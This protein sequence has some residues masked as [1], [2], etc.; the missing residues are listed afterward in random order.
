MQNKVLKHFQ[1][2]KEQALSDRGSSSAARKMTAREMC[3]KLM[4]PGTFVEINMF[5]KHRC[6]DF[7]MENKG[8]LGDSVVT[9]YGNIL[10]RPVFVYAQ[11][12]SVLGGSL[13]LAHAKKIWHIMDLAAKAGAPIVGLCDSAGARIQ[14]GTDALAG[15]GGIFLRNTRYSGVIPQITAIMGIC[16][17]GAVYSPAITD[18]IYIV[19]DACMFITGP[20]VVKEV[21]G[22]DVSMA[23]LGG[24]DIHTR[25]SGNADFLVDSPEECIG[26]IRKLLTYIPQNNREKPLQVD[27]RNPINSGLDIADIVPDDPRQPLNV[28]QLINAL[29]DNGDFYEVKAD[30]AKNIVVGFAHFAGQSVGILANQPEFMAGVLDS[31][32]SDKAARFVRLCDA[33]NIPL[34][35]LVDVPGYLPGTQ[36]EYKGIIR[37]GAKLLYAYSEATV[38][39]ITVILRK[40]YGGAY[41]GMCS[42]HLGADLVLSWPTAEIAVM[43]PEGAV[44]VIFKKTISSSSNPDET[45]RKLIQDYQDKFANPYDACFKQ[46]VDDVIEPGETRTRII[47]ALNML[48]DKL[49]DLHWRKHGN[50]PL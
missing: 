14:E 6:T 13:G 34:V 1:S 15:Y 16:A 26:Q 37:H 35:T 43:G 38:P 49:E 9:G 29:V 17:G 18:F 39:K 27:F 50:I 8:A 41:I 47:S 44:N 24:A 3:N 19:K 20:G 42:K 45:K 33:F 28:H 21:M 4:D 30:Y 22:E 23:Q 5:V 46:H 12:F 11:D 25:V 40:A 36:E 48:K 7:G 31:N 10:E 2:L 32:S